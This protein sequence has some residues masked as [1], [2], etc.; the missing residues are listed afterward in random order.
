M[1]TPTLR[2]QVSALTDAVASLTALVTPLVVAQSSTSA[3]TAKTEVARS[4]D[5]RDFACTATDGA[6]C[7]R[8]L[9]SAKRAA[10]HG[11]EA[12]GHEARA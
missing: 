1:S 7:S 12:G 9:R 11:V 5:G 6:A 8:S 2:A 3:P 4:K 10:T